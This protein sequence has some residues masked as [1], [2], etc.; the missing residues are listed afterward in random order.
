[1]SVDIELTPRATV[2][3]ANLAD[4]AWQVGGEAVEAPPS[5]DPVTFVLEHAVRAAEGTTPLAVAVLEPGTVLHLIVWPDGSVTSTAGATM[6][7]ALLRWLRPPGT[8]TV[9]TA[10]QSLAASPRPANSDLLSR[11]AGEVDGRD[12]EAVVAHAFERSTL[13]R[14]AQVVGVRATEYVA[15][16]ARARTV[17]ASVAVGMAR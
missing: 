3:V 16:L 2:S 12:W 1:M 7:R 17:A 4:Q 14:E 15:A 5:A 11:V 9:R 6:N 13:S 10:P 8:L